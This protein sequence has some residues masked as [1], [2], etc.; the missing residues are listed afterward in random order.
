M[1]QKE[2]QK[3]TLLSD[4]MER[5]QNISYIIATSIICAL[6]LLAPTKVFAVDC[7]STTTNGTATISSSCTFPN[8]VDGVDY[9]TGSTNT[10]NLVVASGATLTVQASQKVATGS[11]TLQGGSIVVVSGGEIKLNTPIWY[12][13]T[14]ND[15]YADSLT[16]QYAQTT[17]PTNG[18]R[19]SQLASLSVAD[20]APTDNTKW[21]YL[22]GY[23]DSDGDGYGKGSA[24]NVCSGNSLPSG[25]ASNNTDCNDGSNQVYISH[26][27][28]YKDSD[29]DGYTAGLAS[30]S[31]C[32]N[33][34][35]CNT[36]TRASD[37]TD[38]AVA[39][40]YTAGQLRDAA[41]GS[42]CDDSNNA[43]WRTVAGYLDSDGDGYGAGAYT[44]CAGA[45]G[46]YVANNTDCDDSN[47]NAWRLRY[48]DVD[49]DGHC[50]NSTTYCVGNDTGYRDSCS[51]YS[52]CYDSNANAYPSSTYCGTANRGDGSF[53]YNCSGSATT[54]GATYYASTSGV[55]SCT[56]NPRT[57]NCSTGTGYTANGNAVGCGVAGYQRDAGQKSTPTCAGFPES[58]CIASGAYYWVLGTPGT[59]GCQ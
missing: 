27:Q 20:C 35:S 19:K 5:H 8:S 2:S 43:K 24:Q 40:S 16:Q 36:A 38:G 42:D 1:D 48:Q 23:V 32:L 12:I 56:S 39:T 44:T 21:Q 13:D 54:C 37:S 17:A 53:D 18:K 45:S 14:D 25:Y 59:Q 26:A 57:G 55:V 33:A 4:K 29:A 58:S 52:D 10:A 51:S 3:L 49:N 9:G 6:F 47:V 22:S 15:N 28:C 7:P 31:T 11:I 30:S 50:P 34:S 46:T 41:N